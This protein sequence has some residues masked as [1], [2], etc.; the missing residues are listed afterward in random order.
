MRD[1]RITSY[2]G[3]I[4]RGSQFDTNVRN[5]VWDRD[6]GL[7]VYCGDTAKDVDHVV[8]R[9]HGGPSIRANAVLAC[10]HCNMQK[11]GSLVENQDMITRALYHLLS[12]GESLKWLDEI[13]PDSDWGFSLR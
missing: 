3:R 9:Q 8:P 5:Y 2:R 1:H 11:H 10:S 6:E 13:E 4:L 12:K 7:C